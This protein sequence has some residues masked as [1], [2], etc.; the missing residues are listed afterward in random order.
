MAL[1]LGFRIY[2]LEF[3]AVGFYGL[4]LRVGGFFFIE[5]LGLQGF[6]LR[7]YIRFRFMV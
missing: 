7:V 1:G 6:W 5:G 3:R 4:E 2:G